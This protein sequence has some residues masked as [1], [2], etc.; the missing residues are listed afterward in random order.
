MRDE[1]R[2]NIDNGEALHRT[3]PAEAA[4]HRL[5]VWAAKIEGIP[6]VFTGW[7][8]SIESERSG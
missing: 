4:G 3:A 5:S 1:R 8:V 6:F 7:R 2:E